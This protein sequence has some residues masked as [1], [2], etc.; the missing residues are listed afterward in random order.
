MF[1]RT[2][3]RER[4]KLVW[5]PG[6]GAEK[7]TE[8]VTYHQLVTNKRHGRN[9]R[10][11]V[12]AHLG[13]HSTV[14]DALQAWVNTVA[15]S[16][17]K[18]TEYEGLTAEAKAEIHPAIIE[19]NGGEVPPLRKRS[20]LPWQHPQRRY[21]RFREKWAVWLILSSN[22]STR[23]WYSTSARSLALD[24]LSPTLRGS[25]GIEKRRNGCEK[26]GLRA[27]WCA[28]PVVAL[29]RRLVVTGRSNP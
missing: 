24:D 22:S 7:T 8:T 23:L 11:K 5:L 9:I 27:A 14:E 10:Q 26:S 19:R 15:V 3:Q 2:K 18:L 21:W 20:R 28:Y 4:K 6:G 29:S 25:S 1:V 12:I 17:C 16:H 13:E